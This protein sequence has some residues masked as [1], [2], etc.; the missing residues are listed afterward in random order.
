MSSIQRYHV[1]P[2]LSEIVVHNNTVY[3]AGQIAENLEADAKS[4]AVEVLGFIDKLLGE[5]GSDK[6]KILSVTIYLADMADYD[7]MNIAWSEW[8][9]AGHTPCRATVEARLADPRYKVEMSVIAAL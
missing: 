6:Q 8:V 4:Q 9:P 3:L 5:I 7:A 1:G 2:R